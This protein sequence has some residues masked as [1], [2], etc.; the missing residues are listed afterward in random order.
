MLIS[1]PNMGGKSCY[2]KQIAVNCLLAQSG[3]YIAASCATLSVLDGVYTRIGANDNIAY[4]KST[5][6][7]EMEEASRILRKATSKS[8]VILDELGRGFFLFFISTMMQ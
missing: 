3:S 6:M 4:G 5:F 7:V 8:L 1:G 2:I